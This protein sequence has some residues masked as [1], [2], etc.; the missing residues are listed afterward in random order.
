[1]NGSNPTGD[2]H[3]L[4]L[5]RPFKP[6]R[7]DRVS[8]VYK[9]LVDLHGGENVLVIKRLPTG[10]EQISTH[11]SNVFDAPISPR[12][13]SLPGHASKVLEEFDATIERLTYEQR[14]E[15]LDKIIRSSGE[16][17]P[18]YLQGVTTNETMRQDV[19]QL[20]MRFTRQGLDQ[21]AITTDP[22]EELEYLFH[23]NDQFHEALAE[24]N[25]V[26]R[27]S[28]IP[29]TTELLQ[30]NTNGLRDDIKESYSALLALEFEEFRPID[31]EYIA[32]LAK[33]VEFRAIGEPYSSI[34][35][36]KI[37]PGTVTDIA[38]DWLT[39]E[40]DP[41]DYSGE[42]R[43]HGPII[44]FLASGT[45]PDRNGRAWFIG[46]STF[47]DQIRKIASE[48]QLL[49]RHEY[50]FDDIAIATSSP[51]QV[52]DTRDIVR[53]AGLPTIEITTNALQEDPV[54]NELYAVISV[55]AGHRGEDALSRL[56]ARTSRDAADIIEN[57]NQPRLDDALKTWIIQSNLKARISKTETWIDAR[58]QFGNVEDI[59]SILE[60]I[61]STD[62]IGSE[63]E[64]AR[65]MVDRAI[66]YDAAHAHTASSGGAQTGISIAP[67]T[68]FKFASHK[69]IFI[70]DL[71]D[72]QY[73]G[74][75]N[76]GTLFPPAWKTGMEAY[77]AVTTPSPEDVIQTYPT[78]SDSS[79]FEA[80][81]FTIYHHER[82]RRELAVCARAA[83][84]RLY[85]TTYEREE[86]G[87]GRTFSKSRY[88]A[89][90]EERDAFDLV[91]RS[92]REKPQAIQGQQEA[93][94]RM[95][96]EPHG[97]LER[98]L[99]KASTGGEANLAETEELFQEIQIHLGD[100]N[101]NSDLQDAIKTQFE[102]AKGEVMRDE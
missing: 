50:S 57:C 75:P 101:T 100:E 80:D 10:I 77:P 18:S 3:Q 94:E 76:L 29:K 32:E 98:I 54:V 25:L 72:S 40:D 92:A 19:G 71:I 55:K 97:E 65:K 33:N 88:I 15:V 34:N 28:V 11:F 22:A 99:Q 6:R 8:S 45:S 5:I 2:N 86:A 56:D 52:P 46:A 9:Q 35:R 91:E 17:V 48:I 4:H 69:V 85:F 14:I 23:I 93:I 43:P 60:F 95:L 83:T 74:S 84:D 102:F 79:E 31:R 30:K 61:E 41:P 42:D 38:P 82:R 66:R 53:E 16:S 64:T 1:M 68:D 47:R 12:I 96:E 49:T 27:T 90:L 7:L 20:L 39:I 44:D 78:Y 63:W 89:M 62:L 51:D 87:L 37:E 21:D 26:E 59:V 67:V 24:R 70:T 58:K 81:P 13:E 73:P 36:T